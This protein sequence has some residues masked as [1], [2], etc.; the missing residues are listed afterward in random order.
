MSQ[1]VTFT[2]LYRMRTRLSR[3]NANT[4]RTHRS[5][6]NPASRFLRKLLRSLGNKL[7]FRL[8]YTKSNAIEYFESLAYINHRR[9][10]HLFVQVYTWTWSYSRY[11]HWW[12]RDS[13][14]GRGTVLLHR[15]IQVAQ[16]SSQSSV[17]AGTA[18]VPKSHVPTPLIPV[19]QRRWNDEPQL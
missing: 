4:R 1:P 14:F 8:V 12:C 3:C 10:S 16:R 18:T 5:C 2:Y 17:C 19:S 7:L 6:S 9:P 11:S 13:C 15:K